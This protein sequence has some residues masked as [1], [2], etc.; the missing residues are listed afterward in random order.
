LYEKGGAKTGRTFFLQQEALQ[1]RSIAEAG[2][3]DVRIFD[4]KVR[5]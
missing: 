4:Y 1:E 2:F 5:R 3:T